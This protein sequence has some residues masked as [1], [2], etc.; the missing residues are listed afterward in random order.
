MVILKQNV[1]TK[2]GLLPAGTDVEGKLSDE[3]IADLIKTGSAQKVEDSQLS[4]NDQSTDGDND[5][6][7]SDADGSEGSN[8]D[9]EQ[10]DSDEPEDQDDDQS[11]DDAV[12][13]NLPDTSKTTKTTT[14][15]RGRSKKS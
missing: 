2:V 6:N 5:Q 9:G 1:R 13:L 15:G 7:G 8:E 11:T 12:E 3:V 10:S 14:R 4:E